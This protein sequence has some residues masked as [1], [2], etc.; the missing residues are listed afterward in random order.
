MISESGKKL[1]EIMESLRK[2]AKGDEVN[3]PFESLPSEKVIEAVSKR[4]SDA[5]QDRLDG[6]TMEYHDWWANIRTSNTESLLR[7][8]IEADTK[9]LFELK[10][11]ELLG[12]INS[13][14][15]P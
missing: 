9:E 15:T 10:K 4:Y 12:F 3:F 7:V 13:L 8:T 11:E 6:L 5:K 2:Y 14:R 1:S